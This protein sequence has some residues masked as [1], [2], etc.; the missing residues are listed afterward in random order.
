MSQNPVTKGRLRV[1]DIFTLVFFTS[2][3]TFLAQYGTEETQMKTS[4]LEPAPLPA[5]GY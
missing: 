3:L 5:R 4:Y 2:I 1:R